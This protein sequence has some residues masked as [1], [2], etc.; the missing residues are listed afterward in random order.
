VQELYV[1]Y[2]PLGQDLFTID[3]P[4]C[5]TLEP[6]CWDQPLFDRL[7][8]GITAVLLALKLNPVIV[9]QI[10]SPAA[11]KIA[12]QVAMCVC[13]CLCVCVCVCMRV[14]L[15]LCICVSVYVFICVCECYGVAST[16]RLL[17]HFRFLLQNIVSF[18]GPFCKTEL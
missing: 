9:Y 3:E 6:P 1:D 11:N 15:Y 17:K 7:C 14:C 2:F 13:L 5:M 4:S 18:I 16:S 8:D 10:N 12:H